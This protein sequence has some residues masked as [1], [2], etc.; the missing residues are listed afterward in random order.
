M[1]ESGDG[2]RFALKATV[3]FSRVSRALYTS[4]KPPAPIDTIISYGPSFVPG[5]SV[6]VVA[7]FYIE[8]PARRRTTLIRASD[9]TRW[10][11]IIS[12][13][14]GKAGWVCPQISNQEELCRSEEHES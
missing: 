9:F 1:I 6:I 12:S 4:P 10:F 2:L 11:E 3:R 14:T 8:R 7:R 13:S 5:L